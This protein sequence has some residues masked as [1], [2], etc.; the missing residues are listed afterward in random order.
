MWI[1][2]FWSI[3]NK[4]V[5]DIIDKTTLNNIDDFIV[6]LSEKFKSFSI[7]EIKEALR[8]LELIFPL[9]FTDELRIKILKILIEN[10]AEKDKK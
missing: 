2:N 9:V 4:K 7:Q 1:D 5:D 10:R 3:K 8:V 6:F